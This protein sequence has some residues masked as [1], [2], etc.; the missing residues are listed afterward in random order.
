MANLSSD[1]GWNSL[2]ST[3][4]EFLFIFCLTY[5]F[6]SLYIF[7]YLFQCHGVSAPI[8][9]AMQRFSDEKQTCHF[10]L[11]SRVYVQS[12]YVELFGR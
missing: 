9:N 3:V 4:L 10:C 12:S 6:D 5:A 8:G 1:S 7:L 2:W 11:T